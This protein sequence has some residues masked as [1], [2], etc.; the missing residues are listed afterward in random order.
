MRAVFVEAERW[1]D[2][3]R[4]ARSLLGDE[5][6]VGRA[7]DPVSI[8]H[9]PVPRW[10]VRW[11]GSAARRVPDLRLQTRYL[12]EQGNASEWEDLW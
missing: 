5:V 12:D 4:V 8:P 2:V 10:Q 6:Y 3:R 7:I 11:T 9:M 1:F